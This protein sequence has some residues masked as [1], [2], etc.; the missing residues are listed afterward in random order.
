MGMGLIVLIAALVLGL[1]IASAKSA[2]DTQNTQIK[3]MTA[4]FILLDLLLA[5]YGPDTNAARDLL[6]RGT[7]TM[8]DRLWQENGSE[9]AKAAPFRKRR[10]R[11]VL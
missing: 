8:A 7:V 1:L 6:R 10:G 3:Q 4:N 9:P 11:R 5:Q 2:H